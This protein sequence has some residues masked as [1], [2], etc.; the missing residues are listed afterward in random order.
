MPLRKIC[1]TLNGNFQLPEIF[2]EQSS[3]IHH[4]KLTAKAHSFLQRTKLRPEM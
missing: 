4:S 3:E 2:T 1:V